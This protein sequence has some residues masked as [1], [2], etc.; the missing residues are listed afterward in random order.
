MADISFDVACKE[1][2][3]AQIA[4]L[5]QLSQFFCLVHIYGHSFH[6][7]SRMLMKKNV[8]ND[9]APCRAQEKKGAREGDT[10]VS[11][12]R[13]RSLF[14]PPLSSTCYAGYM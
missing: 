14:H 1:L 2:K 4:Q 11:L 12:A 3:I 9:A 10:R 8:N 7:L 5:N 13:A 6:E